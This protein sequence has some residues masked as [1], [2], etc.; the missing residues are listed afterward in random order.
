MGIGFRGVVWMRR[1]QEAD[2]HEC[3]LLHWRFFWPGR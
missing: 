3:L 1:K 2:L